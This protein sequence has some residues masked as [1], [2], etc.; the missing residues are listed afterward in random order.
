MIPRRGLGN[1]LKTVRHYLVGSG[2][3]REDSPRSRGSCRCQY[4]FKDADGAD[5]DARTTLRID[6][7]DCPG[8][9]ALAAATDCRATVVRALADRDA[10]VVRVETDGRE[11]TYLDRALGLLLAAGR[12]YD[13][14]VGQE[15]QTAQLA[16]RDPLRA[17][18]EATG[19]AGPLERAAAETGLAEMAAA[20]EGYGDALRPYVAPAM[21]TARVA[22][23]LPVEATLTD[24]WETRTGATVRIYEHPSALRTYHLTPPEASLDAAELAT[25]VAARDRLIDDDREHDRGPERAIRTVRKNGPL[26]ARPDGVTG[27]IADETGATESEL[28]HVLRRHTRGYGILEDVFADAQVSDAFFTPPVA[29]TPLRVVVDG[30]RLRTNVRLSPRGA[31]TLAS[32]LRRVSGRAFSRAS[33]TL[34]TTL[35]TPSGAI[36]VAATT[37]P[38]SDGYGFTFRRGGEEAWTLP[39]L[40]ECGTLTGEAAGLVSLAIERGVAGLVSGGRGAG[41]TSMLGALLW[42]LPAETRGVLIEDTPELPVERLQRSGR[43][44]Q[45]LSV[46]D[47]GNGGELAPAEA[48]R[49]ALRLGNGAIVVGEV[50]GEEAAALYEAMRVGASGETV[51]G[52]IHGTDPEAVRERVLTDLGVPPAAFASTDLLVQLADHRVTA[53]VEVSMGRNG[54]IFDRLFEQTEN[55]LIATGRI[56]R[57]TSTL[58]NDLARDD[59]SYASVRTRIHER[60]NAI[61]KRAETGATSAASVASEVADRGSSSR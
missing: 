37:R 8:D 25:I 13:R 6:A 31:A 1:A 24:R 46:E 27:K 2:T 3:L 19:R 14:A 28:A 57:G 42:E 17:A 61:T 20:V 7:D 26:S 33:P 40:V 32:R 10:D 56:D 55:G 52:T 5:P 51:L 50:R 59:E 58:V 47:Q 4:T 48:V 30:E 38:I 9:G 18:R 35:E 21:A 11:F 43:D 23:R 39:R 44:V 36:R 29:E 34:D 60:A 41:K 53:I 54:V 12:F 22:T 49:T 15:P 16:A 45:R